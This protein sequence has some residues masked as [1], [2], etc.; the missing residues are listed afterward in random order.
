MSFVI[1][2]IA[3]R[4]DGGDII[5]TR[6]LDAAE[7]TIG[8]GTDCDIQLAD[9]GCMLRHARLSQLSDGR[10][11][12]EATGG[13]PI[14]TGGQFVNRADL[15]IGRTP[16]VDIAS[17]RLT[18][19]RGETPDSIAITVERTIAATDVA[20]STSETGVFSLKT[21][22]PSRRGIAWGLV[23]AILVVG[24]FLP[25][26]MMSGRSPD[27]P[28]DMVAAAAAPPVKA[29]KLVPV[30]ANAEPAGAQAGLRPDIV[31]SSGPLSTAHAGLANNCGACHQ[32]AF[33]SVKDSACIACHKPATTPDHAAPQRMAQGRVTAAGF[34]ADIHKG[35][36][37]SDG[38]CAGCH[39]EHEGP[40]GALM[41]AASFCTDCH[42]GL[43]GRLTDTKIANV[44]DWQGH[45]QFRATL[46]A[47]PSLDRPQF[48]RVSL[49]ANPRENSG[50][51]YPHD[52]HQSATNAVANM[53]VKQGLPTKTGALGCA[54]C[55]LPDSDRVRFKPINMEDNCAACHDLAFA[56]DGGIVRTLPHGKP[57]QVAGIVRDFY[58]SQALS[59]RAG[60]QRLRFERRQVGRV[61]ELETADLRIASVGEARSRGD[62]AITAIFSKGGVCADCHAITNT[63]APSIGERFS[64]A[65]VTLADHYLPKGRFPHNKHLTFNG[66]T[67]DAACVACH[68]GGLTSKL[69]SDVLLPPVGQCRECHGATTPLIGPVTKVSGSCDT[70]HGY[71]ENGSDAAPAGGVLPPGHKPLTA[72][73][74]VAASKP[75][76]FTKLS[77]RDVRRAKA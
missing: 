23:V 33:V 55:H 35:L 37:L 49:A 64:V 17:H 65:A 7:I 75:A 68:K 27:L 58:L 24:L 77:A 4:A 26:W 60:V 25:L 16:S 41:V 69:S 18:L 3:K 72:P 28:P 38:R 52:I 31:W 1:R 71:H 54:Y 12:I 53:A 59:P 76:G 8:R 43:S 67:G 50:L 14:E 19:S 5:R 15:D 39:K 2:Q 61:A 20:D 21:A 34:V 57:Q 51:V 40:D 46:V 73:T 44:P 9:L 11:A 66:K 74:R 42:Q 62:A 56:R 10:V 29:G 22:L 63:G 48:R 32:A 30:F 6:T 45:P 13:I 70:C 36:N 47:A